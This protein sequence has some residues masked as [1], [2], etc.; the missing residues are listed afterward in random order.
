MFVITMLT[1]LTILDITIYKA[2]L[3]QFYA[4]R[5]VMI[6]MDCL[7]CITHID[8]FHYSYKITSEYL[9]G[10][11]TEIEHLQLL[12]EKA[13]V[14][15]QRDFEN[16]WTQEGARLQVSLFTIYSSIIDILLVSNFSVQ[17]RFL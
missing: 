9:K 4:L 12:R 14:K 13:K 10:L 7:V 5:S 11:R 2:Q 16:W 6:F 1:Y 15:L 3:K 8:F 17:S